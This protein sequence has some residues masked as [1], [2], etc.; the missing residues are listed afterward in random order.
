MVTSNSFSTRNLVLLAFFTTIVIVIQLLGSFIRFGVFSISL[1]LMPIV[2]GA[3]LLGVFA[4]AWL[5]MVFGFVVLISGDANFFIAYNPTATVFLVIF[6]GAAAGFLAGVVYTVLEKKNKTLAAIT[7]AVIC[8][9][10]NT[11]I[12]IAGCYI[13]F[14]PLVSERSAA[15][16]AANVTE[17]IFLGMAGGNFLF[18]LSVNLVLSSTIVRLIQYKTDKKLQLQ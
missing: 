9:V 10:V 1:V 15:E 8:P 12:F 4:G 7:A 5:G 14:L 3:A 18:E 17:F 16:G 13:F 6:K 2:V 11:G